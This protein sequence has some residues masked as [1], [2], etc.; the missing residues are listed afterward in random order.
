MFVPTDAAKYIDINEPISYTAK[1]F[2]S[3]KPQIITLTTK[4]A[5]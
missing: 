3:L 4:F 2:D 1:Q 5:L